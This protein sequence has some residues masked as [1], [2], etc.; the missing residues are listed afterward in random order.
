MPDFPGVEV[1]I[2]GATEIRDALL[3]LPDNERIFIISTP[4][5]GQRAIYNLRR[6]AAG[7]IEYECDTT[8]AP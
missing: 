2:E 7:F 6:N 3:S 4:P 1:E 8:P 5:S